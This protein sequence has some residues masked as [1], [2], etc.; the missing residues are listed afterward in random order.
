VNKKKLEG[1]K[2]SEKMCLRGREIA[3]YLRKLSPGIILK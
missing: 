3:F 1:E 2:T